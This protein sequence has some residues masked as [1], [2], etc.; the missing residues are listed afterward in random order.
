MAIASSVE[1]RCYYEACQPLVSLVPSNPDWLKTRL[2]TLREEDEP[3]VS[4]KVAR[5]AERRT[6]LTGY[7]ERTVVRAPS[8]RLHGD[9]TEIE[10]GKEQGH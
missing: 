1:L 10:D 6:V 3:R 4:I 8:P 7:G 5:A 2:A 9:L